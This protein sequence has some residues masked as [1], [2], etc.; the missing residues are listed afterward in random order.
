MTMESTV[1]ARVSGIGAPASSRVMDDSASRRERLFFGGMAIAC[2]LTV[3]AGFSRSYYLN[4]WVEA[5]FELNPL[6]HW[7]GAVFTAWMLLLVTQT[8]LV[9]ANRRDLHRRLG[10]AG[11]GL[12]LAM[13]VL[14]PV[15]AVT[16]TASGLVADLGPPPLVFLAVPLVGMVVFAALFGAA[17]YLTRRDLAAHKRLMLLATVELVTAAV[18]R[19]PIVET[20]GPLGFFGVANLFVVA[21]VAY[22]LM[23]RRRVHA[24]TLWGGLFLVASQP[25][26]L[27]IGGSAPWIAFAGW[28]TS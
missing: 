9:A 21:I 8:S 17:L 1:A 10:M 3:F 12:G 22:D 15:V 25:L 2:T 11:L 4:A 23:T 27:M 5:P 6:L 20:W 18:A 24:A 13:I 7:H 16:R 26:R 28:L 14:G 19:L